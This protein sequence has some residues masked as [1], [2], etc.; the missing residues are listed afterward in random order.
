MLKIKNNIIKSILQ[1]TA[2]LPVLAGM[3]ACG[4]EEDN[5]LQNCK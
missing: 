1:T 4:K 2:L 3:L 5:E